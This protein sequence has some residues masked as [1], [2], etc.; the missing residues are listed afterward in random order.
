MFLLKK[1]I[2]NCV[3][4]LHERNKFVQAQLFD[5]NCTSLVVIL[6]G[7]MQSSQMVKSLENKNVYKNK[8]MWYELLTRQ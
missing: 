1:I 7:I 5:K 2:H 6:H 8:M 4:T 3:I